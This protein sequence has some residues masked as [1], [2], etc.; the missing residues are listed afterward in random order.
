MIT[1]YR[2]NGFEA[3][4]APTF[5]GRFIDVKPVNVENGARYKEIDTGRV[6]CFDGENKIW[7]ERPV[8]GRQ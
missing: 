2:P 8:G 7:Y 6:Y 5:S 3:P 1:L 4:R